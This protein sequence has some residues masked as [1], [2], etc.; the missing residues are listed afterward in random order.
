MCGPPQRS[1]ADVCSFK[2][3]AEINFFFCLFFASVASVFPVVLLGRKQ[4]LD[5]CYNS[6]AKI[7]V[8]SVLMK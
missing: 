4:T 3:H 1:I 2:I 7:L 8:P 5:V 6:G